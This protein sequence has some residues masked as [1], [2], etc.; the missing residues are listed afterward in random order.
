MKKTE[1]AEKYSDSWYRWL[2][3][4]PSK[5]LITLLSRSAI[6][7]EHLKRNRAHAN[8]YI[9]ALEDRLINLRNH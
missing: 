4:Q 8:K 7:I 6:E 5:Y 2:R 1:P 3:L 9:E